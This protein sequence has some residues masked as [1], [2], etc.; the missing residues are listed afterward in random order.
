MTETLAHGYSS[1]STRQ[2]LSNEYQHDR[3]YMVFK[4]LCILVLRTKVASALEGFLSR[5]VYLTVWNIN[6]CH[7]L[8]YNALLNIIGGKGPISNIKLS[9]SFY[10]VMFDIDCIKEVNS[11][12]LDCLFI[13]PSPYFQY[14]GLNNSTTT[15]KFLNPFMPVAAKRAPTIWLISL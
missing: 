6:A 5:G 11:I 4:N 9:S 14:E 12:R 8:S 1:E 13:D 7:C 2:E 3:V 10:I 15:D